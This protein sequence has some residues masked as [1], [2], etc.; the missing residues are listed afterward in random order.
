MLEKL[1][2]LKVESKHKIKNC[3]S[4]QEL[5]QLKSHLLGKKS[6]LNDILKDIPSLPISER[7]IIGKS[8]NLLKEELSAIFKEH[9]LHLSSLKR[10]QDLENQQIDNQ[11]PT[12]GQPFGNEHPI[13]KV[14]NILCGILKKC[15]FSIKQGPNIE[16]DFYN[17]EALNILN[18]T[19]QKICM[20][21]FT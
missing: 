9:Q 1:D 16:T 17:F 5:E 12:F 6:P 4:L 11:L 10:K 2:K 15:G 20:I 8:A 13:T 21:H 19:Q 3:I 7:P 18:I 14:T